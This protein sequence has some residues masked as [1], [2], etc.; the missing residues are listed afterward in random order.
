MCQRSLRNLPAYAYGELTGRHRICHPVRPGNI[1]PDTT[2]GDIAGPS[3]GQ[4]PSTLLAQPGIVAACGA[5]VLQQQRRLAKRAWL[6]QARQGVRC[7]I[8]RRSVGGARIET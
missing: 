6:R 7:H 1:A 5:T 4:F 3:Y 2:A 8:V